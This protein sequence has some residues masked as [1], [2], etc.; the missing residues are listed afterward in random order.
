MSRP[1]RSLQQIH[2]LSNRVDP[3]A[4][5]YRAYM[6]VT[7]LEMERTRRQNERKS[8]N[9]RIQE[10]DSRLKE[11]DA[12]KASLL[13]ALENRPRVLPASISGLEIRGAPRQSSGFKVRY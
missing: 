1:Q 7:C 9:G 6:K 2:T 3:G 4:L 12:E 5:P 11:I 10:I 13:L 8:A